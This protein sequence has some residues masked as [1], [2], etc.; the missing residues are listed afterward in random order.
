MPQ[1]YEF[2]AP[3]PEKSLVATL[4]SRNQQNPA[5]LDGFIDSKAHVGLNLQKSIAAP[6]TKTHKNAQCAFAANKE[7]RASATGPAGPSAAPPRIVAARK[8]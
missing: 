1:M 5:W 8:P 7:L 3:A 2:H 6:C 4:R